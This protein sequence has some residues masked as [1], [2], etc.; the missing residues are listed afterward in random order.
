MSCSFISV[1]VPGRLKTGV[2]TSLSD[3]NDRNSNSELSVRVHDRR[4]LGL[5]SD[6]TL[7]M[8]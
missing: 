4:K 6:K 7:S 3:A 1:L 5:Y 2:T 8:P